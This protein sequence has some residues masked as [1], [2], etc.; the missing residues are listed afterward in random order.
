MKQRRLRLFREL[1]KTWP[2]T[3]RSH[4]GILVMALIFAGFFITANHF[5]HRRT[6][7]S[8]RGD[9]ICDCHPHNTVT[10]IFFENK[11]LV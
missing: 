7:N 4:V 10:L 6:R 5:T 1:N 9:K 11:Y 3:A 8:F 2:Q